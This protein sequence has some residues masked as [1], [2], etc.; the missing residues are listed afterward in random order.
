MTAAA[1]ARRP[2]TPYA[3]RLGREQGLDLSSIAGSGPHGRIV[4]AD[5]MAYVAPAAAAAVAAGAAGPAVSA[6]AVTV[7]LTNTQ[8]LLADFGA[9]GLGVT[10]DALLV[11]SAALALEAASEART[12]AGISIGWESGTAVESRETVIADAHLGL[13]SGVFA[14]LGD[15]SSEDMTANAMLSMRRIA[16]TG[17]RPVAMPLLPGRARR[18]IVS[19]GANAAMADCLLCFDATT[20]AEDAA[21]ELLARFRDGLETPLRLLA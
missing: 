4:A 16:Q 1:L 19:A 15:H 5:V 2:A 14:R 11:R 13:L 8:K 9:A 12:E 17:V 7:D 10:L 21:A 18:L 3:R 6:F 20:V